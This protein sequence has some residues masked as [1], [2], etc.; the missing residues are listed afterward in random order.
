MKKVL[1]LTLAFGLFIVAG[2]LAH[3][4][5]GKTET[6]KTPGAMLTGEVV[7]LFCYMDHEATGPKHAACAASCAKRG[8]PMAILEEKTGNVYAVVKGHGGANTTLEPYAGKKVVLSG[9]WFERGGTKV[10]DLNTVA[11]S[12]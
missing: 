1:I 8:V 12:K 2:L 4:P 5:K 7:C 9:R 11:E 10:F 3:E 6:A